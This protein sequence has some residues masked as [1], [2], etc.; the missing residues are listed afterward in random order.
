MSYFGKL[1]VGERQRK[2]MYKSNEKSLDRFTLETL[3]LELV[4]RVSKGSCPPPISAQSQPSVAVAD[5]VRCAGP[6]ARAQASVCAAAQHH[7]HLPEEEP[8]QLLLRSGL[9]PC[10]WLVEINLQVSAQPGPQIWDRIPEQVS[11]LQ[12]HPSCLWFHSPA[13]LDGPHPL[14]SP[15]SSLPGPL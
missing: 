9:L 14:S 8:S 7:K 12:K 13:Y 6:A 11:W 5:G 10:V 2:L 1:L 15:F 4:P 3:Q